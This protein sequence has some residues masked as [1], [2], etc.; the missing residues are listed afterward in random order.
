MKF[1]VESRP[2]VVSVLIF[3]HVFLG[4]Q[5]LAGGVAFI[6]APD[7]S[8]LQMP[9]SHLRNTP[10]SSLLIPGLLLLCSQAC[11]PWRWPTAYGNGRRGAGPMS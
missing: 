1:P 7:G 6:L 11:I 10:F 3:L 2:L 4:L 8:L 9:L 5:G